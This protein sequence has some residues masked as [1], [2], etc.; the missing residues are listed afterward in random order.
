MCASGGADSD[1]R[2]SF[3]G[4]FAA[5]DATL[6]YAVFL[7]FVASVTTLS[8]L[9]SVF[10][11]NPKIAG[12]VG[13]GLLFAFSFSFTL[14]R[15]F[16]LPEQVFWVLTLLSP[17]AMSAAGSS[18]WKD[19]I[20]W[21]TLFDGTRPRSVGSMSWVVLRLVLCFADCSG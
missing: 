21:A 18:I 11:A 1:R 7:L 2:P 10:F 19:G 15:V 6:V 4:L 8:F 12:G 13:A 3:T 16:A 14:T 9:I 5:C 17:V 20:R